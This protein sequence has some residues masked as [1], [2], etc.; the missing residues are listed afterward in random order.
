MK[1][2]LIFA[3]IFFI[4][5]TLFT[6]CSRSNDSG[7]NSATQSI[8]LVQSTAAPEFE[9]ESGFSIEEEDFS[10]GFD[11]SGLP[12][13]QTGPYVQILNGYLSDFAGTWIN[14][15]GN[16][17]NL[18]PDGNFDGGYGARDFKWTDNGIYTW[19]VSKEGDG[20]EVRLYPAG[21]EVVLWDDQII[22]TDTAKV[23]IAVYANSGDEV[24]YRDGEVPQQ[25]NAEIP[26]YITEKVYK[27][28]EAAENGDI[29]AF[30]SGLPSW[31]DYYDY[32]SQLNLLFN[33]FGDAFL[34]DEDVFNS[35]V[36][37]GTDDLPGIADK[38]FYGNLPVKSRNTKMRVKKIADIGYGINV[39]V[40]NNRNEETVYY[41]SYSCF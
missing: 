23:R 4:C 38:L 35:A 22:Q 29:T 18:T 10:A 26:S 33:F 34:I 16:I 27:Y 9:Y 20:Y 36:A 6:A 31:E 14:G 11:P 12:P 19:W 30:R 7:S 2:K 37:E 1:L 25:S 32:S 41:F 5:V 40:I 39:T 8:P 17:S 21:S 3:V 13:N 28:I 24:Y 15:R